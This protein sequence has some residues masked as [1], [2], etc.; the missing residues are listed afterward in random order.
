MNGK[1][2]NDCRRLFFQQ[3]RP[4]SPSSS[5]K[6]MIASFVFSFFNFPLT[7]SDGSADACCSQR[8]SRASP[9]SSS[10]SSSPSLTRAQARSG[11]TSAGRLRRLQ[12][13]LSARTRTRPTS[14]S[15]FGRGT[16]GGRRGSRWW[17]GVRSSR[18]GCCGAEK[19][20]KSMQRLPFFAA[21]LAC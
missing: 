18:G 2:E 16:R 4:S 12:T 17:R 15:R 5:M 7:F 9:R 11:V 14:W 6:G 8:R 3:R 1:I 10:P 13:R 21:T 20:E 19:K